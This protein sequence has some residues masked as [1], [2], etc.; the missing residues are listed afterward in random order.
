MKGPPSRPRHALLVLGGVLVCGALCAGDAACA[1]TTG[2]PKAGSSSQGQR[3]GSP[4]K[5]R[6]AASQGKA[7]AQRPSAQDKP[8]AGAKRKGEAS[9]EYEESVR[10][11]VER[12]RQRRSRRAQGQA[13]ARAAIGAIVPWPMPPA[14]IIRHTPEVHGE[15]SALLHGLR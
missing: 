8:A 2:T 13:A 14:L 3:S 15:V 4:A 11:T 9:A 10:Q 1:Q 12:R 6:T 7:K 5:G